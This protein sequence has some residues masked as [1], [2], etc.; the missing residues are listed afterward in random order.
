MNIK[1]EDFQN[2]LDAIKDKLKDNIEFEKIKSIE[3]N[4]DTK[5]MMFKRRGSSLSDGTIIVGEDNGFIAIDVSKADN[6]V[7]S[8][9]LK[10]INDKTGIENIINWFLDKY[11]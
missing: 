7:I 9:V 3:S 1:H 5:G 11:K 10:D 8:F 6:E 4:F 2:I